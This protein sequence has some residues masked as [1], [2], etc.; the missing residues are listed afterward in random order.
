MFIY[1]NMDEPELKKQKHREAQKKYREANKN[2]IH[3]YNINII[4]QK[5]RLNQ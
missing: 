3:D 4:K 2:K 5:K 1:T